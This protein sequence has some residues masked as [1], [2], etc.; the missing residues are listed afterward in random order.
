[1]T[2]INLIQQPEEFLRLMDLIKDSDW[3]GL[4]T[5]FLREKSYF[6]LLCLI[7]ISANESSI[8]IDP[9]A[10][11]DLSALGAILNQAST[12]KVLHSC[13]QDFEVFYQRLGILDINLF[14]TQ[15]AAAF[16]G[17]GGQVSYAALVEE[18]CGV[19]LLKSH[20]RTDWS[21]RPLIDEQMQYAMDDV[22]Y[23]GQLRDVLGEMLDKQGRLKW[24]EEECQRI[25]AEKNYIIDPEQSWKRLKG[26]AKL[27]VYAQPLA[28]AL[29]IWRE[30][31]AQS[32]N[33]PREWILSS[34]S[35][36]EIC[37]KQPKSLSDLYSIDG[38]N[39]KTIDRVGEQIM[40]V[41]DHEVNS[42]QN[43][44]IWKRKEPLDKQQRHIVKIFMKK[45][46]DVAHENNLAQS[47]LGNRNDIEALVCGNS[48]ISILSGWRYQMIGKDLESALS[49]STDSD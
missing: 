38:L 46:S 48:Q 49:L 26:A 5:E 1:M 33:R 8:C 24:F 39:G 37:I 22:K 34:R 32:K 35:L 31:R 42:H 11:E 25:A 6:P 12:T 29:A 16:C 20:T 27:P 47:L 44:A 15:V 3:I 28:K 41:L 23:L 10:I 36:M 17:Y 43:S 9:L 18:I 4:D 7:Q 45:I 2:S 21:K 40:Q 19:K 30:R 13:R 14:D